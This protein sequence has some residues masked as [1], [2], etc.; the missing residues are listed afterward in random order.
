MNKLEELLDRFNKTTNKDEKD[1][2][3]THFS[4][5][6]K[7]IDM[8]SNF[9]SDIRGLVIKD[10]V[11]NPEKYTLLSQLMKSAIEYYKS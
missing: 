10:G 9:Y 2:I 1:A 3:S 8:Q 11:F 5:I 6:L 4:Q 7:D